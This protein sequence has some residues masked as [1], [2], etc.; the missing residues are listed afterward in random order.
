MAEEQHVRRDGVHLLR[1]VLALTRHV[2]RPHEVGMGR[3]IQRYGDGR[4]SGDVGIVHCGNVHRH[5]AT[6]RRWPNH[7]WL[8]GNSFLPSRDRR[9]HGRKCW[10]QTCHWVRRNL[11]RLLCDLCWT[12]SGAQRII[13]QDRSAS[14]L[15][16]E[17]SAL[18][19]AWTGLPAR[20]NIRSSA[21]QCHLQIVLVAI[22]SGVATAESKNQGRAI[23][24]N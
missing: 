8:T 15:C 2:D 12:R 20:E 10:F 16:E 6:A 22:V 13:W 19:L 24:V 11:L 3:A 4:I 1:I 14:L 21:G 5:T 7:F 18:C 9:F 23:E 17:I